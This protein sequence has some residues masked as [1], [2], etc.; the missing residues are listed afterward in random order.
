MPLIQI[1][2]FPGGKRKAVTLSYDDGVVHD[3]RLVEILNR[4]G[5][6]AS[7]HLNS[8]RLGKTGN[9]A[10]E[11]IRTLFRGHEVSAHSVTHPH[12]ET[13]PTELLASEILED[14]RALEALA[15]YPIRGMSYPYGTF[16]DDIVKKLPAFGIEY[17]RTVQSHGRFHLPDDPLR[18]HPTCHHKQDLL[19]KAEEFIALQTWQRLALLYVWGHSYEFENDKNWDLLE[20][21]GERVAGQ[22]DSLWLATNIDILDYLQAI[23]RLRVGVDGGVVQNLSHRPVWISVNG[24]PRQIAPGEPVQ[25]V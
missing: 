14:R 1:D 3:R 12:L 19:E 6:K 22:S 9:L 2:L 10:P 4:H 21:F 17:A 23:R 8:S 25:T 7:F 15:G 20:R 24:E 11:E 18:W 13:L 5:L 16:T